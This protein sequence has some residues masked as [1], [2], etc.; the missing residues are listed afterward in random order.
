MGEVRWRIN[1]K[2]ASPESCKQ[3]GD[4]AKGKQQ[5]LGRG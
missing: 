5:K 2:N 1:S 3:H 4:K